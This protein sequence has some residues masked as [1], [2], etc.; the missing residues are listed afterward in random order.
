MGAVGTKA[1]PQITTFISGMSRAGQPQVAHLFSNFKQQSKSK[2]LSLGSDWQ[3]KQALCMWAG[4]RTLPYGISVTEENCRRY[5]AKWL[6]RQLKLSASVIWQ[7]LRT[8]NPGGRLFLIF[9]LKSDLLVSQYFL[10]VAFLEGNEQ[11]RFSW[12]N[13]TLSSN[14]LPGN[15]IAPSWLHDVDQGYVWRHPAAASRELITAIRWSAISIHTQT[16]HSCSAAAF[17]PG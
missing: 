12:L 3:I 7:T 1:S 11:L 4:S 15:R 13:K 9:S 8:G 2:Q 6:Y 17:L 14:G 10:S 16:A 5:L